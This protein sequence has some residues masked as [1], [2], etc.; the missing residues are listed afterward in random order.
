MLIRTTVGNVESYTLA[1]LALY[2]YLRLTE[3]TYYCPV[4][5][6]DSESSIGEIIPGGWRND[7]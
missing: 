7:V 1:C 4:S 3:I 5:F 2:N 6:V